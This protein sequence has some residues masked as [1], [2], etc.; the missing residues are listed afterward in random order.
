MRKKDQ[1]KIICQ[2]DLITKF[3]IESPKYGNF[4]VIIDT[5]NWDN[6]KQY[7]WSIHLNRHFYAETRI[8]NK[9]F[10]LHKFIL[11]NKNYTDHKNHNT[12]DN[13][14]FNIRNCSN[15]DNKKNLLKYKNNKTGFKGVKKVLR[16]SKNKTFKYYLAEIHYNKIYKFLGYYK[17]KIDAANAYNKAAIKYHGEFACLNEVQNG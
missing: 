4:E 6:V 1:N 2:D 5:K 12:L 15:S 13:T 16:Y 7:R 8:N 11:K 9:L 17:N 14:E 3:L 10:S